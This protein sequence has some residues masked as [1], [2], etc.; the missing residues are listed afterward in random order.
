MKIAVPIT[1]D[2]QIDNHFGHCKAYHL[3]TINDNKEIIDVQTLDSEPGCGCK[4]NI[5]ITLA[6]L[7]V[8]VLLAGGIGDGAINVINKA[9]MEVVRGCSGNAKEAV[10]LYIAGLLEDGGESCHQHENHNAEGGHVCSH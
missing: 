10:K 6:E 8:K 3:F 9:G 4:S 2:Y 5:A 1:E 7:G